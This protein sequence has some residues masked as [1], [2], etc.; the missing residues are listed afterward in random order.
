MSESRSPSAFCAAG[1]SGVK[2]LGWAGV[3]DRWPAPCGQQH[4]CSRE[5]TLPGST[6]PGGSSPDSWLPAGP[7]LPGLLGSRGPS[8]RPRADIHK[9]MNS[10]E[11]W[12]C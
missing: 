7:R 6:A 5:V 9:R 4:H 2:G 8:P 10:F 1:V 3:T 11:R 12:T